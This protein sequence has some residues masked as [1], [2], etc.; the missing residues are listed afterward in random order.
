VTP[1][2]PVYSELTPISKRRWAFVDPAS[3]RTRSTVR[4]ARPARGRTIRLAARLTRTEKIAPAEPVAGCCPQ[5]GLGPA[6]RTIPAGQ[7][8]DS[9]LLDGDRAM[10]SFAFEKRSRACSQSA[11]TCKGSAPAR[12]LP[13]PRS[14]VPCSG[15]I[16]YRGW[17]MKNS[18]KE[19]V[20]D[21]PTTPVTCPD[22]R[23]RSSAGAVGVSS[24]HTDDVQVCSDAPAALRPLRR[25]M[26][27]RRASA[28]S[29]APDRASNRS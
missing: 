4:H 26:L 17:S 21:R 15:G 11:P 6:R 16:Q 27:R 13:P 14:R 8:V 20:S 9:G 25:L 24:A 23:H 19:R 5:L 18:E 10:T 3:T 22:V 2:G 12:L 28:S 29:V 7:R 1:V